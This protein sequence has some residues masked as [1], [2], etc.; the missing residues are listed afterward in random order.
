MTKKY[1]LIFFILLLLSLPSN[2]GNAQEREVEVNVTIGPKPIIVE[3]SDAYLQGILFTNTTELNEQFPVTP[4]SRK[5]PAV[6]NYNNSDPNKKSEYWLK[7]LSGDFVDI[8]HKPLTDLCTVP[9]CVGANNSYISVSNIFWS[10]S[11]FSD[12]NN[13]S[14]DPQS[15]T[16]LSYTP[17]KIATN[18]QPGMT[19]YV[20]YWLDVPE[21]A[22][23]GNYTSYYEI[24]FVYA[25]DSCV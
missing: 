24:S 8:C 21:G 6:W 3:V 22:S 23:G 10:S 18:V 4:A 2:V 5:N 12:E 14:A 25:G 19:V 13:P 20:R 1:L 15:L 17:Q 11:F 9:Y 7:V 16:Q